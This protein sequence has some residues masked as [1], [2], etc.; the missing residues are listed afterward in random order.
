MNIIANYTWSHCIGI[1]QNAGSGTSNPGTNYPHLNNRDLDVGNCSTD[2]RNIFNLTAIMQTPKF[3]DKLL[4]AVASD[5][6]FS[7][8]YRYSSGAWLNV[9]S[10]VDNA[11]LGYTAERPNGAGKHIFRISGI[12]LRQLLSL[13]QLAESGCVCAMRLSARWAIW[14]PTA[15]LGPH[16]FQFDAALVRSF[17]LREGI[18]TQFRFEAFNV[19]NNVRFNNPGVGVS[20][21]ATF[22]N[23]TSAQDPRILQLAMKVTF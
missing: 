14:A 21:T 22:G 9:T 16:F 3:S 2:R 8:I 13:R 1:S 5:W 10:G 17:R 11:L 4:H 18:T 19:F 12:G 15:L 20:S 23:I 6:Q 7:P